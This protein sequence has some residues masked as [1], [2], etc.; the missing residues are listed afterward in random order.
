[1]IVFFD[2]G[3]TLIEGPS[4]G[5]G[6]RLSTALGIADVAAVNQLLFRTPLEDA[7]TA[8]A[9]FARRFAVAEEQAYAEIDRLWRAQLDEAYVLPGAVEAVAR[10][11]AAGVPRGYISNIWPPFYR[12]FVDAFP[13]E[14]HCPQV[15]SFRSGRMKPDLD[16][17]R[18]A[19]QRADVQPQEAVMIGDTYLNDIA[20]ALELGMRAIWILHR[21][22]KERCAITRVI[23][24]ELPAPDR[25]LCSIAD[26]SLDHL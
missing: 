10:M 6:K 16:F 15:L 1:M 18:E 12:K 21:P 9:E 25:T 2:I 20:P 22:E 7:A 13:D 5:P 4:S 26:L 11:R 14:E 8:A 19:L 3:S 17:Y 23:N 24:G